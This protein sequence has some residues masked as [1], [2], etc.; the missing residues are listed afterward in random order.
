VVVRIL[1]LVAAAAALAAAG[2]VAAH[3]SFA[4]QYDATKPVTLKGVVTKVEWLNPHARFYIDV[5]GEDGA[6][7]NW[8]WELNSPNGLMRLGW[9]RHSLKEGDEV[10]AEGFLARD[11]SNHANTRTVTRADGQKM[12]TGDG[13]QGGLR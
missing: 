1:V 5:K 3:H 8:E 6:V 11:G 10:T 13:Q 2:S 12:F 9:T 4:A 7:A